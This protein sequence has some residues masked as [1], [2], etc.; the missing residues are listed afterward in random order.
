[1]AAVLAGCKSRDVA[2]PDALEL[3]RYIQLGFS[4]LLCKPP[5]VLLLLER[6]LM[7]YSLVFNSVIAISFQPWS[8]CAPLVNPCA[9]D[10]SSDPLDP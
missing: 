4:R 9:L 6:L 2:K 3:G 1:M 10:S 7:V 5:A 8:L